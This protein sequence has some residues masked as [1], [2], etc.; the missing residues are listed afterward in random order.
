VY[1][2]NL[3]KVAHLREGFKLGKVAEKAEELHG[4]TGGYH[5]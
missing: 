1:Y 4:N 3:L 2:N 5:Q